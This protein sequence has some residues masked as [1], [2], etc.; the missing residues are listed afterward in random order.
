MDEAQKKVLGMIH[1][2]VLIFLC[3]CLGPLLIPFHGEG[4]QFMQLLGAQMN[5][6][7]LNGGGH[8]LWWLGL[9]WGRQDMR[10]DHHHLGGLLRLHMGDCNTA[11]LLLQP[12][13]ST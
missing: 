4:L 11:H 8:D 12:A 7:S 6:F 10:V 1:Q 3:H 9:R 13:N 5:L 2:A